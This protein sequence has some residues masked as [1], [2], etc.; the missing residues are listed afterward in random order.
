MISRFFIDRPVFAG[1]LSIVIVIAGLAAMS[2][3]PIAQFPEI[4]PPLL[5]ITASYPGADAETASGTVAAP[6]EQQVNGVDNM[7]YV[8]ST[9]ANDGTLKTEVSF[10]VGSDLDG[11][12]RHYHH[13]AIS[14]PLPP[15]SGTSPPAPP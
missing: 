6:I 14:V 8:K 15:R 10:E 5:Q 7:L 1:V 11:L 9:N 4:T 3:L 13:A 2:G 12:C